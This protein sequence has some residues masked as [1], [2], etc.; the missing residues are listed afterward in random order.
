VNLNLLRTSNGRIHGCFPNA[1]ELLRYDLRLLGTVFAIVPSK[2]S[3]RRTLR[4]G[5]AAVADV[6]VLK[7][8]WGMRGPCPRP[9]NPREDRHALLVFLQDAYGMRAQRA[10]IYDAVRAVARKEI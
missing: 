6:V 7:N 3:R 10:G 4:T 8:C 1:V 5:R 9:F 2:K